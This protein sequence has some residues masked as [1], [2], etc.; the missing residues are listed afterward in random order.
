MLK[1]FIWDFDGTLYNSY[2]IITKAAI[3]SFHEFGKEFADSTAFY[4]FIKKASLGELIAEQ[5]IDKQAFNDVFHSLENAQLNQIQPFNSTAET[6]SGLAMRG[7]KQ[8]IL[9]HRK[10]TSTK[11]LLV[12]DQLDNYFSEIVGIDSGFARKPEP[13]SLLYLLEKYSLRPDETL[14]I[15][16]RR[17][18]VEA[19]KNA[20]CQ[21]CLFDQDG[22]FGKI[23]ADYYVQDLAE[24]LTL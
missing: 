3:A 1:N 2:P 8:F 11:K 10:V 20:G 13:D 6:I 14:M 15:G 12:R 4:Q 23:T 17:L 24:I 19:G 18:D 9:T 7:G 21:T 16:D 22:F 5:E